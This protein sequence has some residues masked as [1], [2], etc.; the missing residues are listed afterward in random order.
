MHLK[1]LKAIAKKETKQLLRDRKMLFLLLFFPVFLLWFFGYAVNFDVKDIRVAVLDK[2]GSSLS[3]NYYTALFESDYFLPVAYLQRDSEIQK[4]LDSKTA[5]CVIVIP[6][7]FSMQYY[8]GETSQ[9]Q[10]LI[11]GVD[12]NTATI[13]QGYMQTATLS[14]NASLSSMQPGS[15]RMA[16]PVTTEPLFLYNPDLQTT[17]FMLPGLITFILIISS[18]ISVA[19]TLVREKERGTM[20]QINISPVRSSELL[21]GKLAPYLVIALINTLLIL[22]IGY[23]VF[24]IVVK[25]SLLILFISVL[26]YLFT[27]IMLG[28]FVSTFSDS[29]QVAFTVATFVSL[30][31]SLILS[32]FIFQIESMPPAVQLLTYI[33]PA[34]YFNVILRAIIL[35]GVGIEAY[36]SELVSLLIFGTLLL[37]LSLL[38]QYK[39][40]KNL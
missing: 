26:L 17:K 30:L 11:D 38:V 13:I 8:R 37:G 27:C 16:P 14:Y 40:D 18:T 39:K 15:I 31:P 32:G 4:I 22:I 35:R 3:R 33:T 23:L 5:Q 10:Y 25:G 1:R 12:A 20:E 2:D 34:T 7:G 9:I 36:W 19:L 6:H 29:Q 28:I 24:N 21:L